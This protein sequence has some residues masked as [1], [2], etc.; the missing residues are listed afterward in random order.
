MLEGIH[1]RRGTAILVA[2]LFGE[3]LPLKSTEIRAIHVFGVVICCDFLRAQNTFVILVGWLW[4]LLEAWV[5]YWRVVEVLAELLIDQRPLGARA[6]LP[7][8]QFICD[9]ALSAPAP[10]LHERAAITIVELRQALPGRSLPLLF[11]DL[12]IQ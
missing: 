7:S 11:L 1:L 3:E 6:T 5:A 4:V 10:R 8:T 9:P 2:C 12:A